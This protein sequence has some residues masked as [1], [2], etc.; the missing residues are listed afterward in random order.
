MANHILIEEYD[1]YLQPPLSYYGINVIV[2]LCFFAFH[3]T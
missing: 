3:W 1:A 2:P